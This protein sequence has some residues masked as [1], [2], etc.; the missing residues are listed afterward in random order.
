[1]AT[2]I[3]S[4]CD[5][6]HLFATRMPRLGWPVSEDL[7]RAVWQE[8][9]RGP[10]P[11]AARWPPAQGIVNA[12]APRQFGIPCRKYEISSKGADPPPKVAKGRQKVVA[13]FKVDVV[14]QKVGAVPLLSLKGSAHPIQ[15]KS[16]RT[17]GPGWSSWKRHWPL[18]GR[19][20]PF[21]F[22]STLRSGRRSLKLKSDLHSNA[23]H[24]PGCYRTGEET[25]FQGSRCVREGRGNSH[26]GGGSARR[27]P[28]RWRAEA[29]CAS[30]GGRF[31]ARFLPVCATT[32]C[33]RG[34]RGKVGS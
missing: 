25:S 30:P 24:G 6:V 22:P 33:A 5:G 34:F 12:N 7:F 29:R 8:I 18:L 9:L 15:R 27:R 19:R 26:R 13:V 1:M 28:R 14:R 20:T 21:I 31:D 2:K 3:T 17:A 16:F 23:S 10:R 11:P 4:V 32:H